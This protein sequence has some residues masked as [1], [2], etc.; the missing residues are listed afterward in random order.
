[1]PI[2]ADDMTMAQAKR[3]VAQE[4]PKYT[5]AAEI[6]MWL[7][8]YQSRFEWP[9]LEEEYPNSDWA[10]AELTRIL[11]ERMTQLEESF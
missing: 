7:Q 2:A 5:T 3:W 4:A 11:L 6:N 8:D 9:K 10:D 1:M